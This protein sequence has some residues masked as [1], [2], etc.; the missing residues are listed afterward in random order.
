MEV[1]V[2]IGDLTQMEVDAIVNPANSKGSMGGG[3][4]KDE[5]AQTMVKIV[6]SFQSQNIKEVWFVDRS[7]GLAQEFERA[8]EG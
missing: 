2:K 6:R 3:L 7:G 4:A 8:L 1:K 5:A